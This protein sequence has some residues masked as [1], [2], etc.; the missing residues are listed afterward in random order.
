MELASRYGFR[1]GFGHLSERASEATGVTGTGTE[2]A[3][4]HHKTVQTLRRRPSG[5]VAMSML[6]KRARNPEQNSIQWKARP[7][8]TETPTTL[9]KNNMIAN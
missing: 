8:R 6:N 2:T 9:G 1:Y 5:Q 4:E 3:A 7:N